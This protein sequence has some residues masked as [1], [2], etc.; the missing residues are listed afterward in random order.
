MR[1]AGILLVLTAANV[2]VPRSSD[3]SCVCQCVNG[4]VEALCSS[5]IDVPPVCAPRV[6]P[7]VPPKVEP[8]TPPTVPPV[9]TSRCQMVQ[10]YDDETGQYVWRKVCY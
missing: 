8:I 7:I 9:G 1:Y 3:A 6:C 2:L 5:T 4:E 10:V